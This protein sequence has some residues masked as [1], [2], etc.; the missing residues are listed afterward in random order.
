MARVAPTSSE[1]F[2]LP[3]QPTRRRRA[4]TKRKRTQHQPRNRPTAQSKASAP[5]SGCPKSMGLHVWVSPEFHGALPGCPKNMGL[6]G[7]QL[8]VCLRTQRSHPRLR[9]T[10]RQWKLS[11][12]SPH[13]TRTLGSGGLNQSLGLTSHMWGGTCRRMGYKGASTNAGLTYQGRVAYVWG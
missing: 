9:V 8:V 10:P 3:Q 7:S 11:R 4:Q 1:V 6:A 13:L 5:R 12:I 2:L